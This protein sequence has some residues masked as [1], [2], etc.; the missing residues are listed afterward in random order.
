MGQSGGPSL[1]LQ[2]KILHTSPPMGPSYGGPFE[3]VRNLAKSLC[4]AGHE[5]EV[6]MPWSEAAAGHV[7]EWEPAEVSVKGEIRIG[8]LGWS[9]EYARDLLAT[10]AEVIHTHGLWLHP[11]WGALAWKKR[12]EGPHVISVRGMLEPWAWRHKA[13]KKRPVWWLW[14]RRN[15]QTAGLLHAT[16]EQEVRSIRERGLTAPVAVI[17]N[18]VELP[19]IGRRTSNI[20]PGKRR[21]LFLS[22]VHPV[23]GLPMLLEAWAKLRPEDWELRIVGPDEGG[24][25]EE[26]ERQAAALRLGGEVVFEGALAG[27]AK[28]AAYREADL[29]VLPTHSENF[30]IAVA[31]AMAHGLPVITTQGAPWKVLEEEGCGW[32]TPV[33]VEGIAAALEDA[34]YRNDEELV[35]MGARGRQ[36][37]MER[38][39]WDG[40]AQEM[41]ACY[42]WLLGRGP[43]PGCVWEE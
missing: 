11:S 27:E 22:R 15:L 7:E 34:I 18:G 8:P 17:P 20:E 16:S 3:S 2:M 25:R 39:S 23:K 31:E 4:R 6:R 37:V 10:E 26:L 9:P 28:A 19:N 1:L 42:E 29:F 5:I 35:A 41:I 12:H 38:F 14:E 32:W 33:S 24:H 13:W 43:K 40:I 36:V 21:A 30:G